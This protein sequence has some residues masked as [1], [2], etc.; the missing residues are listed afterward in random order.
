MRWRM[1]TL[2]LFQLLEVRCVLSIDKVFV[3]QHCIVDG[4]RLT[5]P[6]KSIPGQMRIMK[7]S[8]CIVCLVALQVSN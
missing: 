4:W 6:E 5:L 7:S 3:L 2:Y 8:P 1:S